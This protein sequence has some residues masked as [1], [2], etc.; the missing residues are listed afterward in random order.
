MDIEIARLTH[1]TG[2]NV[3]FRNPAQIQDRLILSEV[4]SPGLTSTTSV[5]LEPYTPGITTLAPSRGSSVFRGELDQSLN[6]GQLFTVVNDNSSLFTI[7]RFVGLSS[8]SLAP[9]GQRNIET[10]FQV[11]SNGNIGVGTTNPT[12]RL[13][14]IGDARVGINTSQG[15]LLTSPNGSTYRLVVDNSGNLSTILVV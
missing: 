5:I 15:L 8:L 10:V 12:S 9:A 3:V 11:L 14:V 1:F 6:G 13:H 7:N 4:S 2:P